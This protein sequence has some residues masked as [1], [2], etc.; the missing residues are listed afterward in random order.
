MR[1]AAAHEPHRSDEALG[2]IDA[3]YVPV[4]PIVISL[5]R[6]SFPYVFLPK[7]LVSLFDCLHA[8]HQTKDVMKASISGPKSLLHK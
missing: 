3:C 5:S 6:F 7:S 8:I 2:L 4:I 1:A